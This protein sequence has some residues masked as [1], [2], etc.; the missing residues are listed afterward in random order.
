VP[1]LPTQPVRKCC[2]VYN[3][4][5]D[6][7]HGMEEVFG[8]IPIRSTNKS[9]N[10]QQFDGNLQSEIPPWFQFSSWEFRRTIV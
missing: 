2:T 5:F 7:F 3:L 8:S 10:L 9:N 4:R 6:S 1:V